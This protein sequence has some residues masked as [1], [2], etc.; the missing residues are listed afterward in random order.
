[1]KKTIFLLTI[2]SFLT[3]ISCNNN[4][5]DN[6]NSYSASDKWYEGGSL[7]KSLISDWK[8]ASEKN[9]LATCAD[10]MA[11]VDNTVSMTEL[12]KRATELKNCIDEATKDLQSANN[13]SV[14]SIASMCTITMGY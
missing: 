7:H 12:K 13:E 2:S 4:S 9:K 1:M 11:N 14:A 8:T 3:T 5:S 10:F 6:N